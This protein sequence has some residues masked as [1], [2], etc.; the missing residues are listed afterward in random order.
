MLER[1]QK[2]DQSQADKTLEKLYYD[3]SSLW[4]GL[5]KNN[6]SKE[7]NKKKKIRKTKKNDRVNELESEYLLFKNK[8]QLDGLESQVRRILLGIFKDDAFLKHRINLCMAL[9]KFFEKSLNNHYL[10]FFLTGNVILNKLGINWHSVAPEKVRQ[11]LLALSVNFL[12]QE[13]DDNLVLNFL[14]LILK[15]FCKFIFDTRIG[16]EELQLVNRVRELERIRDEEVAYQEQHFKEKIEEKQQAELKNINF[17]TMANS[18]NRLKKSMNSFNISNNFSSVSN[19]FKFMGKNNNIIQLKKEKKEAISN[20]HSECEKSLRFDYL[21]LI[22]KWQTSQKKVQEA[23]NPFLRE[24]EN[25]NFQVLLKKNLRMINYEM[26]YLYQNLFVFHL[27][28]IFLYK[29]TSQQLEDTNKTVPNSFSKIQKMSS[30]LG[31]W[32]FIVTFRGLKTA[33]K[34]GSNVIK[35]LIYGEKTPM[36]KEK[37]SIF[38]WAKNKINKLFAEDE[39][40][41]IEIDITGRE[42]HAQVLNIQSNVLAGNEFL[43]PMIKCF[44]K[45]LALTDIM[46]N[47]ISLGIKS[48]NPYFLSVDWELNQGIKQKVLDVD[49]FYRIESEFSDCENNVGNRYLLHLRGADVWGLKAK[50]CGL[51]GCLQEEMQAVTVKRLSLKEIR[52]KLGILDEDDPSIPPGKIYFSLTKR[53]R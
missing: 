46:Y 34:V 31:G 27:L 52:T 8:S 22:N 42:I 38:Q 16:T 24:L 28:D 45:K 14:H 13:M 29:K 2:K 41:K 23:D 20:L 50:K 7:I 4:D 3:N 47:Q 1:Y 18:S 35:N 51:K 6:L 26:F 25:D 15:S 43:R 33:R 48:T 17:F 9:F 36:V 49:V 40:M 37:K 44:P 53:L 32:P 19:Q 5:S 11:G 30:R 12:G 10:Y 39:K 21:E